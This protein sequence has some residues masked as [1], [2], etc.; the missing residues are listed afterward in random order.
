MGAKKFGLIAVFLVVV[1]TAVW[2]LR[3]K[4]SAPIVLRFCT[5]SNYYPELVL[6]EFTKK[7]GIQLELSYISSNEELLA[8]FKAGANEFDLIQPS[9]YMVKTMSQLGLLLEL[10]HSQLS[11][12]KHLDIYFSTLSFDPGFKHSVPFSFG[13]TGIAINTE[14]VTPPSDGVSW[15]MLIDSPAP[16]KTSALDDMREVFG[17]VLLAKGLPLNPTDLGMLK[18]AKEDISTLKNKI[19]MFSSEPRALM[20]K[21][22]LEIAHIFSF[23]GIHAGLENPKIKYF[24]PKEGATLWVDTFAIPK[25]SR[26]PKEA[27]AFIS[28]FLDPKNASQI[29]QQMHIATPNKTAHDLLPEAMQKDPVLYPPDEL[30]NRLHLMEDLGNL[31]NSMSDL[32]AELKSG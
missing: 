23:D 12:L 28:F 26:H 5:W 25:Q 20:L 17:A 14:R 1:G 19:L 18:L 6:Q 16:K 9:D 11:D 27:H 4:V 32:W 21:G 15:K 31:L 3:P 8:K 13:T 29:A 22:E 24:I 30:R 10:D 7:T 2:I